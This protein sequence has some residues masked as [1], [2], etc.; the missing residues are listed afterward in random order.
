MR[1]EWEK[2]ELSE[3]LMVGRWGLVG[4]R[5]GVLQAHGVWK[6]ISEPCP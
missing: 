1:A 4:R 5:D 6:E 3:G 2:E